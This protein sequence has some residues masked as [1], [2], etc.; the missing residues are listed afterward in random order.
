MSLLAGDDSMDIK[1]L[2][3]IALVGGFGN[4]DESFFW[5]ILSG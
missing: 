4:T 2:M 5:M 3:L 1:L